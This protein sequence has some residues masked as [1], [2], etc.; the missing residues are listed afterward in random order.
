MQGRGQPWFP[1]PLGVIAPA[2]SPGGREPL[3]A[4]F[5]VYGPIPTGPVYCVS[6]HM[7]YVHLVLAF[8]D[9]VILTLDR[10]SRDA[11]ACIQEPQ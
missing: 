1:Q 6:L 4:L 8:K 5:H 3:R 7:I 10:R 11:R 2:L 9:V